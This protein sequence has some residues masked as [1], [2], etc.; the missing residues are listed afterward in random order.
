MEQADGHLLGRRI[1]KA[2]LESIQLQAALACKVLY[3]MERIGARQGQA[4]GMRHK[5]FAIDFV[6][7]QDTLPG[8]GLHTNLWGGV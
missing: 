3:G 4:P 6:A 1:S 8:E 5:N 7:M 2:V